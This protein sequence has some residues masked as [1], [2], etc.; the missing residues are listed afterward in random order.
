LW[1][2][3][4]RKA[5]KDG[6]DTCW[7]RVAQN[8]AGS[9]WGGQIIPRIGMEVMV[10]FVD[11]DPDRPLVMGV[12]PNPA[13]G[14]PYDLPANK[15]RSVF[16]TQTHKGFGSNELRF[17]D[18]NG[19]EEIYVH[20][21]RDKNVVVE[22]DY[23]SFVRKDSAHKTERDHSN[24]VGNNYSRVVGNKYEMT[25]GGDL[26]ISVGNRTNISGLIK[27]INLVSDKVGYFLKYMGLPRH[28]A[29]R[30]GSLNIS[31]QNTKMETVGVNSTELV[32]GVKSQFVKLLSRVQVGM[33]YVVAVGHEHHEVVGKT[34]TIKAGEKITL[35]CGDSRL[36]MS[37][38]GTI[39][40]QG[41]R[42]KLAA[43]R[44]DSN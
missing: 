37:E 16:K 12:V 3:W 33:E 11:G 19:M 8:W 21:Q 9:T 24:V 13:N 25:S 10:A 23:T 27:S 44:V 22:N 2:P 18:E 4:D 43:D 5:K 28:Q 26:N 17:E 29:S 15:T 40:L 35:I 30:S 36:E 31:V 32:G 6:S 14:V 34:R 20:A 1:F 38:D 42:I 7:V 39:L 41:V